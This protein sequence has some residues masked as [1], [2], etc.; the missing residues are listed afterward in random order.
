MRVNLTPELWNAVIVAIDNDL[1][2]FRD[3]GTKDHPELD[4]RYGK[5]LQARGEILLSMQEEK[6]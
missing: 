5:M 6:K 1:D 3:Y 4:V 2:E